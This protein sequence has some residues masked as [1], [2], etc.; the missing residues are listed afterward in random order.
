MSPWNGVL[1]GLHSSLID[2]LNERF[3]DEKLELGLPKRTAGFSPG[4]DSDPTLWARVTVDQNF[5]FCGLSFEKNQKEVELR[6]VFEGVLQ[7]AQKAEFPRRNVIPQFGK[8][9]YTAH[10]ELPPE[11]SSC[12]MIIWLPISVFQKNVKFI[13][14]LAVGI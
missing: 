9:T 13:F 5:G 1:Q 7:R 8:L 3:P 11:I 12:Q 10:C 6:K 14:N 2:E 4:P